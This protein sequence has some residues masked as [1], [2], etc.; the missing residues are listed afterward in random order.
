MTKDLNKEITQ[1]EYNCLN[2]PDKIEHADGTY[3]VYDYDASGKKTGREVQTKSASPSLSMMSTGSNVTGEQ[4]PGENTYYCDNIIYT[5]ENTVMIRNDYGYAFIDKDKKVTMHYYLRDHEGSIRMVFDQNA[6]VEQ[7]THYYPFGGIYADAGLNASLQ[8]YKYNGKE[9]DRTSDLNLYDYG[10]RNY[11]A[12]IGRWTTMDPLAE[13]T[14]EVSPYVYCK[15][16]PINAIDVDGR[17]IYAIQIEAQRMILNTLPEDLRQYVQFDKKGYIRQDPLKTIQSDSQNF[18]S[19]KTMALSD[20][21]V[22]VKLDDKFRYRNKK[23]ILCVY[24]M[25]YSGVDRSFVGNNNGR[26]IGASTG[27]T[28]LLGKTLFP[29]SNG[30]Q[31]SPNN[32]IIVVINSKLSEEGR[33]QIYSHE[34]NGH[35]YVY[36]I[37]K[38]DR[39]EASHQYGLGN[40]D[41]NRSLFDLINKSMNE[42]IQNMK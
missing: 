21:I 24:P 1:I 8:P 16:N 40:T 17:K 35:A 15:D 10:A 28:G 6:R 5:P 36:I 41:L 23:G 14:P 34:A 3:E 37:T 9:L 30:L 18:Q 27:E 2:L 38:G 7:V 31:N 25:H 11:D 12:I 22:E 29:D 32:N 19:L 26:G 33:A 4:L 42:T 20:K 39:K 13:R